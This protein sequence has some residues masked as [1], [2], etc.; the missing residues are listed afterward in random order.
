MSRSLLIIDKTP[1]GGHSSE[2]AD[3]TNQHL[4][5]LVDPRKRD[6]AIVPILSP[7]T[8]KEPGKVVTLWRAVDKSN[9][10]VSMAF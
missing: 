2:L 3:H 8:T 5:T 1:G 4:R 7:A 10:L 9:L 6:P